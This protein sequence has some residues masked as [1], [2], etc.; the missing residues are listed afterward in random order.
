MY[1]LGQATA[2]MMLTATD[3]GVG[4]GHSGGVD[5]QQARRVLALPDGYLAAYLIGL[6]YPADGP[7]RPLVKPD[8][9]AFDDVVHWSRW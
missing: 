9:R 6:G 3:L 4:S 5:Q 1:D 8:R 7:L 2:F